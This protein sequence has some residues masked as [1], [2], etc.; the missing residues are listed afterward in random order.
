M[1]RA[2]LTLP[3]GREEDEKGSVL[4]DARAK[5]HVTGAVN[6]KRIGGV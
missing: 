4:K 2:A 1:Q 5:L 6:K 3:T